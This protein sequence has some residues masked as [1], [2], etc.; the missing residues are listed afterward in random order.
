MSEPFLFHLISSCFILFHLISSYFILFHLISSYFILFHLISSYF[1]LFHLISSYFILFLY[2]LPT[3]HRIL[4]FMNL[5]DLSTIIFVLKHHMVYKVGMHLAH[6]YS[7]T[8]PFDAKIA[9]MARTSPSSEANPRCWPTTSAFAAL[10]CGPW[11]ATPRRAWS[12]H[13]G[14]G[15]RFVNVGGFQDVHHW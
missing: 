13:L 2:F 8:W 4:S 3:Y 6:F 14:V 11:R 9:K 7:S 10:R 15:V 12:Q 5:H 1:I